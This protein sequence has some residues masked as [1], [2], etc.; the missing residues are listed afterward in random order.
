MS[1]PVE[2]GERTNWGARIAIAVMV[3]AVLAAMGLV[4][5][6]SNPNARLPD[7]NLHAK[8]P[9]PPPLPPPVPRKDGQGRLVS[10]PDWKRKPT[11]QDI[12]DYYPEGAWRRRVGGRALLSCFVGADTRLK[13]CKVV[14]ETPADAGFGAAAIRMSEEFRMYPKTVDG[15]PVEGGQ[16]RI[17]IVFSVTD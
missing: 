4:A 12:V 8:R 10:D 5:Y 14:S 6:V 16:V 11:S 9:E 13:A 17:P 7:L 1:G 2:D 15:K 3:V